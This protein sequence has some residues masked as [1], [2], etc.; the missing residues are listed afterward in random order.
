MR[1]GIQVL[2]LTRSAS[3]IEW[4]M[5]HA[6]ALETGHITIKSCS[7]TD[8]WADVSRDVL[9]LDSSISIETAES[10][11]SE[12]LLNQS[13][14]PVLI[15]VD[16]QQCLEWDHLIWH[17]AQ[18]FVLK[19]LDSASSIRRVILNAVNRVAILQ[20]TQDA[21]IRFRAIIE[22]I[23][24]GVLILDS[25]GIVLFANPAAEVLLGRELHDIYGLKAPFDL[26]GEEQKTLFLERD[27]SG[28]ITLAV[29]ASPIRWEGL[30]AYLHTMRDITSEQQAREHLQ[31]ARRSA[32]EAGSMKT[33]FLA[34]MSHEL[35]LPLASIIGFAQLLEEEVTSPDFKE[36]ALMIQESGNRLLN[37]INSVL[38]ATRLDQHTI[39]PDFQ[40]VDLSLLI[41]SI[42]KLLQ[43]LVQ[44]PDVRLN[45]SGPADVFVRADPSFVERIL[46]NL[47]GNAAKFTNEGRI[48]VSWMTLEGFAHINVTDSGIGMDEEFLSE[49]FTAF[50]QESTGPGRSHDGTGLGLSIV[51]GMVELMDGT[52]SV[53]S[54]KNEGSTFTFTL[55]LFSNPSQL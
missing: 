26:K 10:I 32:E 39:L 29:Q 28:P 27:D 41:H 18:D 25:S 36:F 17:G 49:A 53:E 42:I 43:P 45:A 50:T 21:E 52:V 12:S 37:T 5:K 20:A 15:G 16:E 55:P 3:E 24:D 35:R 54:T 2:A 22:Q 46:T 47:I 7:P 48:D 9:L 34:N 33:N 31:D 38:E 11:L 6:P 14:L 19:D 4:L 8:D 30:D 51:K 1:I 44:Q 40:K 13:S 23:S